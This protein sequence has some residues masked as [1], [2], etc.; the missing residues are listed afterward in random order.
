MNQQGLLTA[1]SE[2]KGFGFITPACGGERVFAHISS[3]AGQGRPVA[4]RRV[5]Y[6]LTE[7]GQGRIRAGSFRYAGVAWLG[8]LMA[9]GFWVAGAFVL[10]FF[11]ILAGLF[12]R[13]YL[14]VSILAAYGGVSLL[15]FVLYGMDKRAAKRGTQRTA[16]NTLHLFELC[17]GWPGALLAQQAFRHKTRKGSYQF[18]FWLAVL[19]NLGALGWLMVAPEAMSWRHQLGFDSSTQYLQWIQYTQ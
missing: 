2:D 13:N 6:S 15:L 7:D 19:A 10:G 5:I 1:W 17:C 16:E 11:A 18:V 9:P 4:N 12:Y 14:P 3:Y 8:A